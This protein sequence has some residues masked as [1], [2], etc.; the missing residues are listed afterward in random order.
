LQFAALIHF[1]QDI[2]TANQFTV[3]PQLRERRPV[4][5]FWQLSA[6]VRVLQDINVSK[7]FTTGR[8]RL[9][10]LRG[11]ATAWQLRRTFHIQQNRVFSDLALD[12]FNSGA[13]VL[14][15]LTSVTALV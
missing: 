8:Q 4:R 12:F 14:L 13:H 10:R 9:N 15:P 7:T 2:A 3:D 5:V 1:N 11:E 6:D